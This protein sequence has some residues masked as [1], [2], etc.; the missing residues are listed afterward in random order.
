MLPL[1]WI[2]SLAL[3]VDPVDAQ[4]QYLFE[5]YNRLQ[6]EAEASLDR[7]SA[8]AELLEYARNHFRDEEALMLSCGY[9]A[10]EYAWHK[11]S[12]EAFVRRVE[13]LRDRPGWELLDY[14]REWLLLHIMSEDLRIAQFLRKMAGI[15]P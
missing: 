4:H 10:A 13:Q 6:R 9:P 3:H 11:K 7:D 15:S 8:V 1:Q 14:V 12:H 2:P 5:L